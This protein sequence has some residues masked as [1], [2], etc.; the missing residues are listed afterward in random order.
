GGAE[1]SFSRAAGL[2]YSVELVGS[3]LTK[4]ANRTVS[5]SA[6]TY[7]A[8]VL[9]YLTAEVLELGGKAARDNKKSRISPRHIYLACSLD[10]ELNRMLLGSSAAIAGGGEL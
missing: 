4:Q 6:A 3:L 5:A 2:Q 1:S 7:M 9:E 10:E 8:A